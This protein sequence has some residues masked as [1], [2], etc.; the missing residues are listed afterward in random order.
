M[1]ELFIRLAA[2]IMACVAIYLIVQLALIVRSQRKGS[3][4]ATR[5]LEQLRNNQRIQ[6]DPPRQTYP[7]ARPAVAES[8]KYSTYSRPPAY[9]MNYQCCE[10]ERRFLVMLGGQRETAIRLL[11]S[12][13][14]RYPDRDEQWWLEKAL[15]DLERDRRY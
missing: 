4:F 1:I 7:P 13:Q 5:R 3:R 10:L 11:A 15:S 2:I 9:A 8:T 14:T 12:I 6:V